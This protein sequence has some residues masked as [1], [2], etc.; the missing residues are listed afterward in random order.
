MHGLHHVAQNSTK[1]TRPRFARSA[2]TGW[3]LSRVVSENSG[4]MLPG[5]GIEGSPAQ[6]TAASVAATNTSNLCLGRIIW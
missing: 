1:T 2:T 3:A 6:C 5:T 4:A